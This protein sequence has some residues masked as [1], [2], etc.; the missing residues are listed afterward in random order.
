MKF[1]KFI[2]TYKV[3]KGYD[4]DGVYGDQ[5]VD[6]IKFYIRDVL[7]GKVESIGNAVEYWNKRNGKYL[8]K[9]FKPVTGGQMAKRGDVFVRMSGKCGHVGVVT[10][11]D[12]E[13]FNTIEQNAGGSGVVSHETHKYSSDFHFLRPINQ[14]NIINKPDV[15]TGDTVTL[16]ANNVLY[17]RASKK[18]Y[19]TVGDLSQFKCG[20]KAQLKKGSK[21]KVLAVDTVKGSLW[22][23]IKVNGIECYILAY[24]KAKDKSYVK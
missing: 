24:S 9:L 17:L 8:K 3:G 18:D 22:L 5:C 6:L 19:F 23:K 20:E 21:V 12:K 16:K 15:H 2:D 14:S 13:K 10:S 1:S 7:D 11:A 4:F